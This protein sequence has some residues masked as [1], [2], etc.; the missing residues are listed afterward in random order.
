VAIQAQLKKSMTFRVWGNL[1]VLTSMVAVFAVFL[2]A[3]DLA[4]GDGI[5]VTRKQVPPIPARLSA[6]FLER[7]AIVKIGKR[8][9]FP[10]A[11]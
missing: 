8:P 2:A 9:L 3:R 10:E 4:H 1:P 11:K 7:K 6:L 5:F